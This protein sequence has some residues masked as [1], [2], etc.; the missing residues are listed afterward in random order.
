MKLLII[1]AEISLL[2]NNLE[3]LESTDDVSTIRSASWQL[4]QEK[5]YLDAQD[6]PAAKTEAEAAITV[7]I[8]KEF[9]GNVKIGSTNKDIDTNFEE[10][11][12][13]A[14]KTMNKII[15]RISSDI[16]L[17]S[18]DKDMRKASLEEFTKNAV[19]RKAQIQQ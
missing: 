15:Y 10:N 4:K 18:M 13:D 19:C 3:N 16:P 12:N 5:D 11:T 8:G 6:D 7:V 2:N 9:Q 14:I 17:S 1:Q